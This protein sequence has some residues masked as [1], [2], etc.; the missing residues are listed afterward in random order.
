M[1]TRE[2]SDVQDVKQKLTKLFRF[3]F[4]KDFMKELQKG[5]GIGKMMD[6]EAGDNYRRKQAEKEDK[7]RRKQ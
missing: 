6:K 2:V 3:F 7:K 5:I 1:N 4:P